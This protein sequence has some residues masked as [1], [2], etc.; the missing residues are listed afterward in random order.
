VIVAGVVPTL[1]GLDPLKL[2]IF[3]MA[4]TALILPPVIVPFVILMNDERYLGEHRNGLLS[5]AVVL[6]IIGLAFVLALVSIPL[7][8]LGG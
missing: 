6:A 5:N 1:L 7:Q 2:T 8:I 3:S 4:L